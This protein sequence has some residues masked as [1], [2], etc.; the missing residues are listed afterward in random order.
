MSEPYLTA[1]R[2]RRLDPASHKVIVSSSGRS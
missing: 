2:F 1:E